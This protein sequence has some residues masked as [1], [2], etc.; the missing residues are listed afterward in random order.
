MIK[1]CNACQVTIDI[2]IFTWHQ[3]KKSA[4]YIFLTIESF[5]MQNLQQF[6]NNML[7]IAFFREVFFKPQQRAKIIIWNFLTTK[8]SFT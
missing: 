1:I 6:Q 7:K 3:V 2:Q 4:L 8:K 5:F